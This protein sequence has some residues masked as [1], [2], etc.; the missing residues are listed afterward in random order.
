[1]RSS[2][3]GRR[4]WL[5]YIAAWIPYLGLYSSAFLLSGEAPL[6]LALVAGLNEVLPAAV[7]GVGVLWI[8]ARVP[9]RADRYI[10]FFGIHV[11]SGLVYAG[12]TAATTG[13][14]FAVTWS[15]FEDSFPTDASASAAAML[16][17]NV[18]MGL[19]LYTVLTSLTYAFRTTA[20]LREE[21][22]TSFPA[23]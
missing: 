18:F 22:R 20:R 7:A 13:I 6:G 16:A 21:D 8:C 12:V 5:L 14:L 2:K 1:M 15:L 10:R 23:G 11:G 4:F 3:P 9:W 19:M 17:W